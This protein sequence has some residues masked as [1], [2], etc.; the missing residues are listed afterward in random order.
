MSARPIVAGHLYA[1]T[2]YGR[3]WVVFASHPCDAIINMSEVI[4]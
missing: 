2:L 1:V 3:T 4:V